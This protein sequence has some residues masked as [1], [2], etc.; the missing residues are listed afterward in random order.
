MLHVL[1]S[2]KSP[3]IKKDEQ[4]A[5]TAACFAV[6][7]SH[8]SP[9]GHMYDHHQHCAYHGHHCCHLRCYCHHGYHNLVSMLVTWF[10]PPHSLTALA[11]VI[12]LGC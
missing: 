3:S 6:I 5:P 11:I 10:D 4:H 12:T 2:Q 1:Y 8:S 9:H 7:L